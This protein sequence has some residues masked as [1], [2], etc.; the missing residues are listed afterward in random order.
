MVLLRDLRLER[1]FSLCEPTTYR[2]KYVV[3]G[4][5]ERVHRPSNPNVRRRRRH[6]REVRR[7]SHNC[8]CFSFPSGIRSQSH[9]RGHRASQ[10]FSVWPLPKGQARLQ[11]QRTCGISNPSPNRGAGNSIKTGEECRSDPWGCH[12]CRSC[13]RR[14][15]Q[16]CFL[17][18]PSSFRNDKLHICHHSANGVR[19][20]PF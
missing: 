8:T 15:T 16:P 3:L 6:I 1:W 19:R 18:F 17:R 12:S 5:M 9:L 10:R 20:S 2:W 7:C 14:R 11:K 4:Y 13:R